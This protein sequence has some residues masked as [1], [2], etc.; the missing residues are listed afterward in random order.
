M[1]CEEIRSALKGKDIVPIPFSLN[2]LPWITIQRPGNRSYL[3]F[4]KVEVVMALR[5]G[6]KKK[7]KRKAEGTIIESEAEVT[8]RQNQSS[9]ASDSYFPHSIMKSSQMRTTSP[10]LSPPFSLS[11]TFS[12]LRR[13]SLNSSPRRV[14]S[15][16][17][18]SK[19][20]G[21]GSLSSPKISMTSRSRRL[22]QRLL[23]KR[24]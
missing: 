9:S 23:L 22:F 19:R 8:S 3:Y 6:L 14:K 10:L 17:F 11:I 16:R 21:R 13:I 5:D 20:C 24:Y 2:E 15:V 7:G 4:Q 18:S 12:P 1:T